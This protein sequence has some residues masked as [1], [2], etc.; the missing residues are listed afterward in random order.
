MIVG[1]SAV[2]SSLSCKVD[3]KKMVPQADPWDNQ[4]SFSASVEGDVVPDSLEQQCARPQPARAGRR[5]CRR[6]TSVWRGRDRIRASQV[7]RFRGHAAAT[8]VHCVGEG[9]AGLSRV[10]VLAEDGKTMKTL[11]KSIDLWVDQEP[12]RCWVRDCTNPGCS[13][14]RDHGPRS[15][16]LQCSLLGEEDSSASLITEEFLSMNEGYNHATCDSGVTGSQV[17]DAG[18]HAP[19]SFAEEYSLAPLNMIKTNSAQSF[20]QQVENYLKNL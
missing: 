3:L 19:K 10:S 7:Y 4:R 13:A 1:V 6:L 2:A 16:V 11:A 8:V 18:D 12:A 20:D 9:S 17:A 5:R 15:D 14:E